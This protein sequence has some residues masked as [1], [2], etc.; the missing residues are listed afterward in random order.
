[1]ERPRDTETERRYSEEE[2][3][4]GPGRDSRTGARPS[5]RPSLGPAVEKERRRD[6]LG[7][8]TVGRGLHSRRTE[9]RGRWEMVWGG[10]MG[11]AEG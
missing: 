3:L 6:R 4:H 2:A 11:R 5:G 10:A 7:A 1:M 8:A 9:S